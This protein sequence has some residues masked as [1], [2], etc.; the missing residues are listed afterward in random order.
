MFSRRYLAM[1][2]AILL[3]AAC[4]ALA[5]TGHIAW[6]WIIVPAL[7]VVLGAYDLT[8]ERHAILRN[9]P[10]WGH[11]RFLFEFIRPEIRQYFVEDDTEEKPFSRAQRSIVYQR[12]KNEVDSRPYGTEIDV[13]AT[14]HEF[15]SHS[16]VPA[17]LDGHD[18]RVAVG[19]NRAQ[20]YSMSIFNI[21]AMSFGSLS[22]NA[23]MA[24]NLGAKKGNFAHDT[25]EGSMS[26]YHR[27]HGGDIIWEIA[28]GYFGCRND[29]GTFNADKFAKQ[30][31]EPQVKMIEV[32]LSQGA[33]PG[34]GGV[35]PAAKITP[36]ISETRGVPMGRDCIS[37]ATHSEFST[38]RELLEFVER[39]RNLSGGKP[40]GFKLCIGHPWE[41]FGIA[42]AMLETGI[43]PDF[44]VVD[45]AEGGTGAAP[46][47]F[48]D[49]IGVPLQ[50]GLLLVHNTL[51]GV[52]LRDKIRIGASGKMITAFDIAKTLAIGADWVNAARGFMFAVG[53]IQAQTCHT[54]RCP[55]GVATQDPVRQ[56][57]L[58]VTDKSDRVFNFHH[59]TLHALQEIVQAAGLRHPAD[60]RA[61]HIVRRVS[62]YEVR[63]MSDLLKYLEPGD[64]LVGQYRYTLY[65][66][67]WPVARSDSFAPELESATA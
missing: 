45:G 13:K 7:L 40:T 26:K 24:L 57:A 50:E 38:P 41:F 43:L 18:F 30:A 28:S 19:A 55:T 47:E 10:L 16:L 9:Y 54:G 21:S 51:V 3:L 65:E 39:L 37:P 58:I 8:Q 49:H 63:L 48:T 60:L 14:G 46:L 23:I 36:E 1:W 29:D 59:N 62:S 32:K 67:W 64:L 27:E 56:R 35:L 66:K 31:S 20:P 53:C 17:K 11:F 15:I 4:A 44:I 61:H 33:K 22:A 5:A 52:G 6:L 12:A 42:K 25:G 34:H 2:G